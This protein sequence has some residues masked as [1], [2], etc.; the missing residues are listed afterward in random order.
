MKNND[1]KELANKYLVEMYDKKEPS[2]N[3]VAS[4]EYT[5]AVENINTA[6]NSLGDPIVNQVW[7]AVTELWHNH[8]DEVL[9]NLGVKGI[10]PPT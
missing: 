3:E 2:L 9:E 1:I 5:L 10:L 4:D 7:E 8:E 6:I